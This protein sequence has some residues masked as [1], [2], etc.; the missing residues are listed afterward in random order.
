MQA[1]RR[2]R[3]ETMRVKPALRGVWTPLSTSFGGLEQMRR[4]RRA[5]RRLVGRCRSSGG[6]RGRQPADWTSSPHRKPE[7]QRRQKGEGKGRE[8]GRERG[9][10]GRMKREISRCHSYSRTFPFSL[11]SRCSSLF[12]SSMCQSA[13]IDGRCP[14][15]PRVTL[16]H[17]HVTLV[18]VLVH[19]R[20]D[21]RH[22]YK[23]MIPLYQSTIFIFFW[24]YCF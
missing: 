14:L 7:P 22:W 15:H 1:K 8:I 21:K 19:L 5:S 16:G 18:L 3:G 12:F 9:R 11:L 17:V 2:N 24:K 6:E 4:R 20:R 13:R 10:E 23:L